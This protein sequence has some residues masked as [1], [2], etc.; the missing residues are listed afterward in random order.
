MIDCKTIKYTSHLIPGSQSS[1][2][3]MVVFL[4]THLLH[5]DLHRPKS[6]RVEQY[7]KYKIHLPVFIYVIEYN[8]HL[9]TKIISHPSTIGHQPPNM[10]TC[11]SLLWLPL[12]SNPQLWSL[13]AL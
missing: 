2:A 6:C 13:A 5:A 12:T 8:V 7:Y 3:R 10:F 4:A 1:E 9:L 11:C